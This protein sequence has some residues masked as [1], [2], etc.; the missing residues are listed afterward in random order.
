MRT[1]FLKTAAGILLAFL[2]LACNET[3]G[4]DG[5]PAF[6][7]TQPK[8]NF[9][10]GPE[11]SGRV[12]RFGIDGNFFFTASDDANTTWVM[13]SPENGLLD[14]SGDRCTPTTATVPLDFH[15]VE[16]PGF[17]IRML[18]QNKT[19][20]TYVIDAQPEWFNPDPPT[21]QD[22]LD[23]LIATGTSFFQYNDNDWFLTGQGTN[24]AFMHAHGTLED[25]LNGG[26]VDF[27]LSAH[28]Q[29]L[30]ADFDNFRMLKNQI[31][32]SP[33]PRDP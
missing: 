10:N 16:N 31:I 24:S 2:P 9:S 27:R 14:N 15:W 7:F 28:W 13:L 12:F 23:H 30:N 25:L 21:C 18:V 32:L 33:D 1:R 29:F 17:V 6:E 11:I 5:L 8:T 20:Y 26:P 4:P 19:A 3:T 22:L